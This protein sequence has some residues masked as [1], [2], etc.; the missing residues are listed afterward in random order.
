MQKYQITPYSSSEDQ[1]FSAEAPSGMTQGDDQEPPRRNLSDVM[2]LW[3]E[4]S[5]KL[6]QLFPQPN[7]EHLMLANKR[8][9]PKQDLLQP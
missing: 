9:Q 6:G 5:R 2:Q 7:S 8:Q 1:A 4:R 3:V